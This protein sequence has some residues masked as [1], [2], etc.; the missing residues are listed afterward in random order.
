M[1]GIDLGITL[2][3]AE[4]L[5]SGKVWE[6]FM[7][8]GEIPAAMRRAGLSRGAPAGGDVEPIVRHN[9]PLVVTRSSYAAISRTALL[10]LHARVYVF[11]RQMWNRF[12]SPGQLVEESL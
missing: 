12:P 11:V 8:N 2:L 6:W 5:R 3:S 10:A 4:N 1:I 7:R 9:E